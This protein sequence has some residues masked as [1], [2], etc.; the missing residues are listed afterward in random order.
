[1]IFYG[2]CSPPRS[3]NVRQ[4]R[5]RGAQDRSLGVFQKNAHDFVVTDGLRIF[6]SAV[7]E[8]TFQLPVLPLRSKL[9]R[10]MIHER[11]MSVV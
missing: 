2:P 1:M 7:R 11:C 9:P 8:P 3:S 5:R 6:I 10:L 4:F